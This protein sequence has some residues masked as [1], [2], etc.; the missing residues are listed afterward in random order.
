MTMILKRFYDPKLAQ[1]SY[2]VGCTISGEALVVDPNRDI[3]PYL[4]A[5]RA[6]SLRIAHVSETHIHADFVSGAREL[7]HRTKARLY[8]SGAGGSEWQYDYTAPAGAIVLRDGTRFRVGKVDIEVLHVPGHT[9]EHLT[10]L[11]TDTS[12]ASEAMGAFTGDFIFVGDVGRPDLLERAVN[13]R[14]TMEQSARQLFKSLQRFR[15]FPD[16]LQ[17]W[18]GHGAG[19]ACGKALGAVPQST[20]GYE[21]RFNW[22]FGVR[23]ETEFVRMVLAGQPDPPRYFAKMKQ[24]NKTGPRLLDGGKPPVRLPT[25]ELAAALARGATVVDTRQAGEF[26][27]GAVPGTINIPANRSF[28]TWAG[29]LLPYDE[30]FFLLTDAAGAEMIDQLT[31]DLSGIGLDHVAGY[32]GPE[33]LESWRSANDTLQVIPDLTLSEVR[34]GLQTQQ[35]TLVDV[36]GE[37]EWKSGHVPGSINVPVGKLD[38]QAGRLPRGRA[39]IVHCQT[40]GRAAIAASVLKAMGHD[41]VGVFAGGYAEW[42]AA[43]QPRVTE[44]SPVG[45]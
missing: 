42:T 34:E 33:A 44:G 26:K 2:L 1:A 31:R 21:K 45:S 11:V 36:R 5:A 19:S 30:P 35:V 10:F 16:F 20:L 4:E 8:L 24:I 18:P 12:S 39:I 32:F 3:A 23:D 37:D 17:I 13:V 15:S 38:Q 40:G 6:D 29:S 9:P 41:H 43:G 27:Q 25:G 14:G 22:A 28:T 7:A